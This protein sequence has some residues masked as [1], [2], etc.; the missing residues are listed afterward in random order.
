MATYWPTDA[1]KIPDMQD[2]FIDGK[3]SHSYIKID[4]GLH[5][6]TDQSSV[7]MTIID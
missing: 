6:T 5:L 4:E 2:F 1:N 7:I 3:I